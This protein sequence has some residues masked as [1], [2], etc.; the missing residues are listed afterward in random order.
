MSDKLDH[1][2]KCDVEQISD[3]KIDEFMLGEKLFLA[4]KKVTFGMKNVANTCFFNSVMQCM[5][6][7]IPLHQFC[8]DDDIHLQFRTK[9]K[10][11]NDLLSAFI[12]YIKK[13]GDT[14]KT[15][16]EIVEPFISQILPNH[17]HGVQEGA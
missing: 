4:D 15:H 8:L 5:T 9:S 10:N 12:E 14:K 7:T 3:E 11:K 2:F 13:T 17:K 6:H 16:T 1:K